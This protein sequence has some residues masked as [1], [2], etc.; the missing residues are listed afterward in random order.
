MHADFP[1]RLTPSPP[2]P[3]STPRSTPRSLSHAEAG[4]AAGQAAGGLSRKT[5][6]AL[7]TAA[8]VLVVCAS[9]AVAVAP[10]PEPAPEDASALTPSPPPPPPGAADADGSSLPPGSVLLFQDDFDGTQLDSSKWSIELGTPSTANNAGQLQTYTDSSDNVWVKRGELHI[11][12]LQPD[13][14]NAYTSGRIQTRDS[15]YPG[16]RLADGTVVETVHVEARIQA[17]GPSQGVLSQLWMLPPDGKYGSDWPASGEIDVMGVINEGLQATQGI[18]YGGAWP[19]N[20]VKD[21]STRAPGGQGFCD[22]Y[23]VFRMD[24][25][26]NTINM[27]IDGAQTAAFNSIALDAAG[28]FASAAGTPNSAPFD[29]PFSIILNVAVGGKWAGAPDAASYFPAT[30]LVDYVRV[31]GTPSNNTSSGGFIWDILNN[32]S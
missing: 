13:R 26:L 18:H 3:Q 21:V 6:I 24:W 19:L 27:Y 5:K 2:R 31:W 1:Q 32:P 17:A 20:Q 10:V 4:L 11:T 15:F 22:V 9:V 25:K 12:A 23:H 28:W 7:W 29:I 8:A 16:M 30:M 14:G